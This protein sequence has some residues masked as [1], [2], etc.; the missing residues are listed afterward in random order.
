MLTS[1][2]VAGLTPLH[3]AI[4]DRRWDTAQL[5]LAIAKAQYVDGE[6]K[7]K[8]SIKDTFPIKDIALGT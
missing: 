2:F 8:V 3:A 7:E 4:A 6:V 1:V 5:V